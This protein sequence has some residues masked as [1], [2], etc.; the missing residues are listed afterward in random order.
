VKYGRR[1]DGGVLD[2][3]A[4]GDKWVGTSLGGEELGIDVRKGGTQSCFACRSGFRTTRGGRQGG[5]Q[6]GEEEEGVRTAGK[7]EGVL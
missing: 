3:I 4:L 2:V 7:G 6:R 5:R 1:E